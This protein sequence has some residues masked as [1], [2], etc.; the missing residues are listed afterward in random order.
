MAP[1]VADDMRGEISGYPQLY[2]SFTPLTGPG[3]SLQLE[4][5]YVRPRRC[6]ARGIEALRQPPV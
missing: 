5:L 1:L 3:I 6:I 2:T 4:R